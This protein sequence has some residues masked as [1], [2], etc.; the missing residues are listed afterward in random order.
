MDEALKHYLWLYAK[1]K[2]N[3]EHAIPLA[4]LWTQKGN[5]AEAAAVLATVMDDQPDAQTVRWYALELILTGKFDKAY[6]V[7][8]KAWEG[9]DTHKETII[10]LARLNARKRQFSRAA[11]MWDEAAR[12][13]LIQG[14]LRWEAAL[15]YSYAQKF[16]QAVNILKPVER[17]NPKYPRLLLFL[18][19]MHFYQKH[20]SQAVHYFQLYL[21][22][23]PDDLVAR[24]LLAEALAFQPEAKSEALEQYGEL[25]KRSE[26]VSLRL[27]RI[28]LLLKDKRWE[29]AEGELKTCPVLQDPKLL[30]EQA[31]LLLWAGDLE[32]ALQRYQMYLKQEPRD[33]EALLEKARV[34]VY[35]GRAPE[36]LEELRVLRVGEKGIRLDQPGDRAVLMVS[37]Q[38]ALAQKD[39]SEALRWALRLYG[40]SFPEK[41]RLPRTWT[42]AQSWSRE[43]RVQDKLKL[44]ERTWIA[45]ALCHASEPEACQLG[46]DLAVTNL[47]KNRHHHA[48]LL[49]LAY[50]LPR[51]PRYEDLARM[52]YRIPGIRVDSPEYVATVAFFNSNLGRQGGKLDYLLHVLKQYQRHRWPDSPGELLALA[53]LAMELGDRG[54]AERYYRRVQKLRPGDQR[55]AEL[56]LQCQMTQKDWSKVLASLKEKPV[57]PETALDMARIYLIRGQYEGVKA[58]AAQVPKHHP[59]YAKACL[60]KTQACR[61]EKSYSEALKTLEAMDG[62]LPRQEFLMEKARILEGMGDRAALALYT[63]VIESCPDSHIARV[64]EARRARATGNPT[65]ARRAF[66]RALQ[67]APQDVEL[68]NELEDVRQR[69]R[70][71]LAS[72]AFLYSQGERRPEET[73][74]PWQF[75]RPDREVFGGLPRARL[76]PVIHPETIWFRDSNYLYGW[77]LRATAGF[78]VKKVVPVQ[79]AVEYREYHQNSNSHSQGLVN[80]GL[81]RLDVQVATDKSRLRRADLTIG[82]GPIDLANR[83]K[84]SGDLILRGYWKRVDREIFQKGAKWFPLP[85]PPAFIDQ[86]R[87]ARVTRKENPTRLL[88]T[89]QLD[90]PLGLK[91]DCTLGYARRDIFDVEPYLFP[92]LYQS[93]NNLGD[94]PLVTYHQITFSYNHQF[95]PNLLWQ[96]NISGALFSD[97]NS[98]FNMY[99]GLTWKPLKNP[100]MQLG[101]TPHYYLTTYSQHKMSYFSPFSYN[102]IG[103]FHRQI[104]RLPTLILQGSAQAVGQH[105]DWGPALHGLAALEFEPLQNFFINPHVFYF[106]EWVDN[107]HIFVAGLSLRYTF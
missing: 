85:P 70:P 27:R 16:S 73:I 7:Y 74:R 92:R 68:L 29:E 67:E 51:L 62:R 3:K 78:I 11:A 65:G 41:H 72:R 106:R 98:R 64:A 69:L 40:S 87:M 55:L 47:W 25:V 75:S 17:D 71:Q 15:T 104:F 96:G 56:I 84:I 6:Q 102:A 12:R 28:A 90:F 33:R 39:W 50:L 53:D 88:G 91:T 30:R 79:M 80:L 14:E 38:A 5:H 24:Q 107:Y 32:T 43:D 76:I 63:E 61:L 1:T 21:E 52:V 2:G 34:L 19:Q 89:V 82:V 26:D 22:K 101:L 97:H 20:W 44:E 18:G 105:G 8:K 83:L 81:D 100:R 58:A 9:G 13:Q 99:Q 48:S 42:E 94:V 93:V 77:I 23:H 57:T 59:D 103:L 60:L 37:I 31:R 86:V 46:A 10:N 4:R 95:R 49:I 45:R 35:L 66:A 36:A 54:S